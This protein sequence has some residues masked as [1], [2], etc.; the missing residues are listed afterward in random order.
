MTSPDRTPVIVGAARTPI[1]RFLGGLAP[2]TAPE[3]GALAIR[4]A[5]KRAGI[6]ASR[7]GEVIMGNVLQGGVGQAPARQAMIKAGIPGTVPAV[8]INKVCGSG[9]QAVMQAAQAIRAGDEQL[10]V[11]GGMESMSNAPHL[12]RGMRNGVKFGAQ[13]MQDL[14]ITDGLWCSFY[15]RHMGGHAE[16]TAKKAGITRAR[17]DQFALESHQKAV[18]AIE[19]GRF[20]A[21]IV[22]VEI[23]GKK[24]VVIDTD[25]SPRKD[26]SLDA[27]AK[28]KP[29]FP[30]DAPKDMKPEELTVTAGNA[31]GLN[32]G[33]AAVVVASEA[34]AKAHGLPILARITGYASGGGDP[35]DL[36]FAPIVAVQNLMAKTGAKISDYDLIEAN[37]AFASQ[38]LADGDGLGWDWNRV[39]VNGGAIALGHPIGASGARVLVTL[40]HALEAQGKRTGMATLCLGGGNAVALSVEKV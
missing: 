31:P 24:P 11:A 34:Y 25:E 12:V 22:P 18:A 4:E 37:E 3:L 20:K 33:A 30:K 6:D 28:L 39:N 16:Y 23:A 17:Q 38:S 29:A 26:T 21:E 5:V 1:G 40:L 35:Q 14:L 10:L 27:L 9:L 8:T 13:T 19:A 36:F 7:I 15:D 32:D 2:L